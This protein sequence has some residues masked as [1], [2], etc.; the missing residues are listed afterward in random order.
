[1]PESLTDLAGLKVG[2]EVF[3]AALLEAAAQPIC[4]VGPDDLIRFANPAALAALGYDR[5]DELFGRHSHDTIHCRHPDR[6]RHPAADCPMLLPRATGETV[7]SDLD[8][9]LRRDGSMFPG[10]RPAG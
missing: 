8:W 4:V 10:A 5:A 7:S 9:F 1:V 2:A 6:T 3:L